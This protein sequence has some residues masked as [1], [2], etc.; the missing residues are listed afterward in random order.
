MPGYDNTNSG[1]IFRA[2][3]KRTEKSPDRTG[4]CEI[5][6]P[7]CGTVSPHWVSGW[8]K[9]SRAGMQFLSLAFTPKDPKPQAPVTDNQDDFG[10][11]IPF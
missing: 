5:A 10:D 3:E 7:H 2:K 6:C 8:L 11:D 4:E 9:K 1:A